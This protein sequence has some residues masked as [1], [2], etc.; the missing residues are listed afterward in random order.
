M[1]RFQLPIADNLATDNQDFIVLLEELTFVPE[2]PRETFCR[3]ITTL[4][5][6]VYEGTEVRGVILTTPSR[7]TIDRDRSILEI[8]DNNGLLF[9]TI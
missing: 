5:D 9:F 2:H 3:N 6:S 7:V 1:L 4:R 8:L